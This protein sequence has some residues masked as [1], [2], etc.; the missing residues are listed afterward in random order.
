M[1]EVFLSYARGD[2]ANA[3]RVATA[4]EAAG[5]PVWYDSHL[6]A[7]RSYSEEIER[8][9]EQAKAVVVLWSKSAAQSQWVR[10]EADFARSAGKLVQAQ[11]D[12]GLPPMPFN[13]IQCADLKSWRGSATHPGWTKLV[14]SVGALVSGE[15]PV[16]TAASPQEKWWKLPRARW[17]IAAGLALLLTATFLASRFV[18]GGEPGR[19]VVAVLPFESLDS[20]DDSLVAGIWEDTRQ[21]LSRNPQLLVLGRH[22]SAELA[23]DNAKAAREAADYLVEASVRSVGDRIQVSANLVRTDDGAQMWSESF[24]RRLDDV[25]A[26]QQEIAREIEGRIRG[27]L[28]KEGGTKPENIATT[29]E[30]YAI[31]SEARATLRNRDYAKAEDLHRQLN[32]IVAM[33]SN[34]APG[35]ALLSAGQNFGLG[36][37]RQPGARKR[38]EDY[39]RRAI[40]LA[41]NLASAHGALALALGLRGPVAESEMRQAFA[42]DPG[43]VETLNWLAMIEKRKGRTSEALKLYERVVEIEPLW[44]PGVVNRLALLLDDKDIAAA[45]GELERLRRLGASDL[46]ASGRMEMLQRKG[47]LSGAADIGLRFVNSTPRSD[48]MLVEGQLWSLLVQLGYFHEAQQVSPTPPFAP[49][50][51]RNDPRGLAM[52]EALKLPPRQFFVLF[53]LPMNAGRV[54][55]LSGRGAKL[56]EL[57][58]AAASSPEEFLSMLNEDEA[59]VQLAPFIAL[60][61]R[62]VGDVEQSG[63]LLRLA[64]SIIDKRTVDKDAW[65]QASLARIYAVQGRPDEALDVL[66]AAIRGGWLP[67]PPSL[68]S[69]LTLDPAFEMIKSNPRFQR[70]RQQVLAHLRKERSELGPVTIAKRAPPRTSA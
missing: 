37:K 58:R 67:S 56:A 48:K 66:S 39:A 3:R 27:R 30:V 52:V 36:M 61:L 51:W 22:T 32:K 50:L 60:A 38:A 62:E 35:W 26:L 42:L 45:E 17:L 57:Y 23:D 68:N 65:L 33:D 70:L 53:P 46:A 12:D 8:R 41:P 15:E 14:T 34:F 18:G 4:L 13:Q 25:F 5:H 47:D 9:L 11:L 2:A 43:D 16:A 1:S 59:L 10:A 6:P 69:D 29:G 40:Q 19:P 44:W 24:E 55:L 20:R 64:E 31:Y 28:A 21:A 63:Q 54:Y 49:P 7:H